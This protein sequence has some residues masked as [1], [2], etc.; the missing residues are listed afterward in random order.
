MTAR[1]LGHESTA[2]WLEHSTHR[3]RWRQGIKMTHFSLSWQ[4]THNR[5]RSSS[6]FTIKPIIVPR[7]SIIFAA[8][9]DH[10]LIC[11]DSSSFIQ[12]KDPT[13]ARRSWRLSEIRLGFNWRWP[14][15]ISFKH[16]L[17]A[18]WFSKQ[19]SLLASAMFHINWLV[20]QSNDRKKRRC[21]S[22]ST[23]PVNL[24]YCTM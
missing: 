19:I 12:R 16:P 24:A 1:H 20:L 15:G 8:S 14:G 21:F 11:N 6:R 22:K 13:T 17:L 5:W 2:I 4:I 3:H 10:L 7:S 9:T 18:R 23:L